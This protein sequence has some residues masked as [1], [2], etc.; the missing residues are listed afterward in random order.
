MRC[1]CVPMFPQFSA[2]GRMDLSPLVDQLKNKIVYRAKKAVED[3]VIDPEANAHAAKMEK[4]DELIQ[5]MEQAQKEEEE[6]EDAEPFGDSKAKAKKTAK[7][8]EKP[9]KTMEIAKRIWKRLTNIANSFIFPLLLASLIANESIAYPVPVRVA[10]F[11]FTLILCMTTSVAAIALGIYYLGKGAY[12]YYVNHM[13][14]GGE[15][16]RIMPAF[17]AILPITTMTYPESTFKTV[18]TY[19]FRYPKTERDVEEVKAAMERYRTSLAESFDY[20]DQ[21]KSMPI[22]AKALATIKEWMDKEEDVHAPAAP[23]AAA[24]PM[25]PVIPSAPVAAAPPVVPVVPTP[26][27]PP[28]ESKDL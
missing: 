14:K 19:P 11:L 24:P 8:T 12:H 27:A 9:S 3:A 21:V 10:F 20:L 13:I 16:R 18:M 22:F 15:P 26:S 2:G 1:K 6:A 25:P 28:V 23:V 5:K 4:Q 17:L 7:K